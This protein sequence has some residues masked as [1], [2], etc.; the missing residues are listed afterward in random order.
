MTTNTTKSITKTVN[1]KVAKPDL[2][3]SLYPGRSKT[4]RTTSI[5]PL[6]DIAREKVEIQSMLKHVLDGDCIEIKNAHTA[7][8]FAIATAKVVNAD[9]EY[10]EPDNR[11]SVAINLYLL[12]V[13]KVYDKCL[14]CAQL[15][16]YG[17]DLQLLVTY[18]GVSI[19]DAIEQEKPCKFFEPAYTMLFTR[20]D[21]KYYIVSCEYEV[22]KQNDRFY[23]AANPNYDIKTVL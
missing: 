8:I 14:I 13:L 11:I 12:N 20:L 19:R 18:N 16:V 22:F 23:V 6:D 4:A 2:Y 7:L 9:K 5:K 17:N 15:T 3:N 21:I 10:G 1:V